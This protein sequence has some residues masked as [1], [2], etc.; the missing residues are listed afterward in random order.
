MIDIDPEP[1][2]SLPR[3]EAPRRR[4]LS[5][6]LSLALK[7]AGTRG[8]V[9][10]LLTGDRRMRALNRK[11]RHRDR[12]TDVLS[13]PAAPQFAAAGF[14][15][16]LAI[17]LETAAR[18]AAG[19]RHTIEEE[20]EILILHGLL[21]LAGYDHESDSGQMARREQALRK[22]LSL[23]LGLIERGERGRPAAPPQSK[24]PSKLKAQSKSKPKSKSNS[25]SSSA[26]KKRP[27]AASA[28]RPRTRAVL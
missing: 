7:A 23:P 19:Q 15:G 9:S 16:D 3:N 11:F 17:S 6:F 14:A 27:R 1:L 4:R 8:E 26:S 10:V 22:R 28:S 21:H 20:I 5:R 2:K 13:F 18:Q 12:A 24:R 25:K